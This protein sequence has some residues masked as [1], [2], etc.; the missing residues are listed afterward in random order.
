PLLK[1]N[2]L[3]PT[4]LSSYR[5]ISKLPFI[6][7]VLEKVA[8]QQL[9]A[10]LDEHQLLDPLQSGFRRLH[11]T[12]TALLKVLNDL[13]IAADGGLCSVLVLLDLSA[14]FDTVDHTVLINRLGQ[15]VGISDSALEWFASYFTNRSFSVSVA[16]FT[17]NVATMLSGVPQG[18][19]LGPL[20][21]SIYIFPLSLILKS[22]QDITYHFYADDIQLYFSFKPNQLNKLSTLVDCLS[23]VRDW[24]SNNYLQLNSG[25]TEMLIVSPP[26]LHSEIRLQL[27][28]VIPASKSSVRNL[29]VTLDQ[30]LCLD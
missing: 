27:S 10:F 9:G 8:E 16:D 17:S 22:F 6:A 7:K 19:V 29:G 15:L 5:P 3:D 4:L 26:S 20:L 18:S 25:K 12:E 2:N 13:L 21:F 14:A 23:Q 30:S 1:K 28:S 24:C 11:S